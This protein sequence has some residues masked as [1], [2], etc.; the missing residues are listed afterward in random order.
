MKVPYFIKKD[1]F[2]GQHKLYIS[3]YENHECFVAF[4]K[5]T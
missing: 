4:I 1:I 3:D 5:E 2:D